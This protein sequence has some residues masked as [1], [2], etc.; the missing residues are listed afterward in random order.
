MITWVKSLLCSFLVVTLLS[1]CTSNIYID[2]DKLLKREHHYPHTVYLEN[3]DSAYLSKLVVDSG[4]FS[5]SDD[6]HSEYHLKL[7]SDDMPYYSC[8]GLG[9]AKLVVS[10]VFLGLLPFSDSEEYEFFYEITHEGKTTRFSYK[11]PLYSRESIWEWLFKPFSSTK[12]EL[13]IENLKYL[14]PK[15]LKIKPKG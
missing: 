13:I 3:T 2:K 1:A 12:D 7:F 15:E 4:V 14:E 6:R 5:F 9:A 10:I 8:G 11:V